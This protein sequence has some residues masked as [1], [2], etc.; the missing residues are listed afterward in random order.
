MVTFLELPGLQGGPVHVDASRVVAVE[1]G[2]WNDDAQDHAAILV[3]DAGARVF[4]NYGVRPTLRELRQARE[5][6]QIK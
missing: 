4:L 3:F 2:Q 1:P 5:R 6:A